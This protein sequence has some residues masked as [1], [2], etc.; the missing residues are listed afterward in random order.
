MK[1]GNSRKSSLG[2]F[3][4]QKKVQTTRWIS[5]CKHHSLKTREI[6]KNRPFKLW[7][8][9][10]LNQSQAS[11]QHQKRNQ[12]IKY[13]FYGD[14]IVFHYSLYFLHYFLLEVGRVKKW[15]V[16]FLSKKY[17][18]FNKKIKDKRYQLIGFARQFLFIVLKIIQI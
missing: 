2:N 7:F 6:F 18:F 10:P 16:G 8:V 1:R 3:F 11:V 9:D 12:K 17:F 5:K 15:F 14:G 13:N 4:R